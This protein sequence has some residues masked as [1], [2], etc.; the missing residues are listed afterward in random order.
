MVT[1]QCVDLVAQ[2]ES[3]REVRRQV[4]GGFGAESRAD[5]G[6][7]AVAINEREKSVPLDGF[8]AIS[9]IAALPVPDAAQR[10]ISNSLS[11]SGKF[12]SIVR[13]AAPSFK[14]RLSKRLCWVKH[15]F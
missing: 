12:I 6:R 3:A 1:S 4:C 14:S 11:R 5:Q 7:D 13:S 8:A 10:R 9:P 15:F 2:L